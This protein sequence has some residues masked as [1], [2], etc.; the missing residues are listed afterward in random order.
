VKRGEKGGGCEKKNSWK[1]LENAKV[2]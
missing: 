1:K 2:E